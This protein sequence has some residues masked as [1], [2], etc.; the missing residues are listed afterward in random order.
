MDSVQKHFLLL[1]KDLRPANKLSSKQ[2]WGF[3]Y[4][5][6]WSYPNGRFEEVWRGIGATGLKYWSLG[7]FNDSTWVEVQIR[8]LE[9]DTLG[10]ALSNLDKLTIES[11]ESG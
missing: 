5:L 11:L 2:P 7:E 9:N 10:T 8:V 1:P 6:A 4:F 3:L